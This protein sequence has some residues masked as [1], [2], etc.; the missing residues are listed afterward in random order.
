MVSRWSVLVSRHEA[1]A[2]QAVKP[3]E[4]AGVQERFISFVL[5]EGLGI[6]ETLTQCG[7]CSA[8]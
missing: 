8:E 5:Y 7:L 1:N 3:T 4:S 6:L 2:F